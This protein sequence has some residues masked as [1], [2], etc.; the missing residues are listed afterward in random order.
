MNPTAASSPKPPSSALPI[1]NFC[2]NGMTNSGKLTDPFAHYK[3]SLSKTDKDA[4]NTRNCLLHGGILTGIN[5]RAQYDE[6]YSCSLRLHKL[7]CILLLKR[8][9]FTSYIIN[10]PVLRDF[11]EECAAAEPVLL[12]L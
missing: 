7:C 8:V 12:Q 2:L 11:K 3:Y 1:A 9:G 6:L 5:Y 4:I 10:L